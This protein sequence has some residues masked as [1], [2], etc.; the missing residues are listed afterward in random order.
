MPDECG[1]VNGGRPISL[2]E[3]KE[4]ADQ[5]LREC[6]DIKIWLFSGELGAGKTTLIKT[7]GKKLGV[8]EEMSSPSFSIINEYGTPM[9]EFVYHFD[10]YRIK[11]EQEA[12]DIGT[13]EYFDSGN[14]CFVEWPE[15]I[16]SLVPK[17]NIEIKIIP[18][19]DPGNRILR[20]AKHD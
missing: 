19:S 13:E 17:E 9:G 14:F 7:L 10:F 12:Y 6:Q 2:N 4:A 20:Y 16:P 1:F 11:N 8:R 3:L 18:G 15:K 5:L